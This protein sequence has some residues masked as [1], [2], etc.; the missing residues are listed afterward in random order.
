MHLSSIG[1]Q[2]EIFNVSFKL[3]N[4]SREIGVSRLIENI[5]AELRKT[6]I[7]RSVY[8]RNN[9]ASFFPL[10]HVANFFEL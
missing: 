2:L 10:N 8:S 4:G 7:L 9:R 3:L 5:R 1:C 6:R